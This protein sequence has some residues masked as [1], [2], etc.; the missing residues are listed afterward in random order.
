[1]W[2][3]LSDMIPL[4]DL[5]RQTISLQVFKGCLPQILL[6]SFL[7]ALTQMNISNVGEKDPSAVAKNLNVD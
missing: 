7:K 5:L 4:S 1:M 2:Q 6:G 3:S